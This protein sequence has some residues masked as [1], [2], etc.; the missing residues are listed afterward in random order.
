MGIFHRWRSSMGQ[1]IYHS[2]ELRSMYEEC[3]QSTIDDSAVSTAFRHLRAAK[4]RIET[5]MTPLSRSVLNITALLAFATKLGMVRR[6]KPEGDAADVFL[7]TMNA[8]IIL[9]AGMMADAGQESL[10]LIRAMDA[11]DMSTADV[12]SSVARLLD[13][14]AGLFHV[15]GCPHHP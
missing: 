3:V 14:I 5:Y 10:L 2:I 1:L 9:L 8:Q 13:R 4:H 7:T 12:N 15:D 6:G 11:E